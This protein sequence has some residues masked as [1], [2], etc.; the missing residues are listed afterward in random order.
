M[1]SSSLFFG[2]TTKFWISSL[3]VFVGLWFFLRTIGSLVLLPFGFASVIAYVFSNFVENVSTKR[4]IS[5]SFLAFAIVFAIFF[6]LI[7][8]F[9]LFI[10]VAV[11]N[12]LIIFKILPDL[13]KVIQESLLIYVPATIQTNIIESYAQIHEQIHEFVP[14][15]GQ[16]VFT[17]FASVSSILVQTFSFFVITPIISFYMIKDWQKINTS[18]V[19]LVPT[20]NRQSF[21]SIRT[22]IRQ[23]LVGYLTGQINIILFLASFYGIALSIVKLQFGFTIGILTGLASIVPYIGLTCGFA[24][25]VIIAFLQGHSLFYLCIVSSIFIVGQIIEG[26]FLTPKL[27]SHKIQ[28]HP[29]WVIFGFLISGIFFGFFGILFALPLTAVASVLVKFYV[30]NYYRKYCV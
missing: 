8:F 27:M 26:S 2:F 5:K 22:E 11:R 13:V 24:I 16:K 14:S 4:K 17:E 3:L 12:L 6:T 28:I 10:P 30:K 29:L 21:I 1:K 7:T 18:I 25:A 9:I 23:R 20:K 15:L 19:S